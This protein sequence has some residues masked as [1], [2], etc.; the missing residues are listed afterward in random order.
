[1]FLDNVF[2]SV[3]SEQDGAQWLTDWQ[4]RNRMEPYPE[5]GNSWA[6]PLLTGR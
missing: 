5:S 2:P 1:M 6:E 4:D 3:K